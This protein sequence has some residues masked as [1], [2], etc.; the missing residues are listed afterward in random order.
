MRWANAAMV[1]EFKA[2]KDKAFKALVGQA[3]KATQGRANPAQLNALL[4][5]KLGNLGA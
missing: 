2:G 1:A 5:K 3:M 4:R